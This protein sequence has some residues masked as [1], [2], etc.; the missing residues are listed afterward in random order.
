MENAPSITLIDVEQTNLA[1]SG[2]AL[3]SDVGLEVGHHT[4]WLSLGF[5]L[6]VA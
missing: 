5:A 2:K 1:H 3:A 4:D 6:P